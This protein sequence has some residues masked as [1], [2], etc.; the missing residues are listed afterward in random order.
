MS[1]SD[2]THFQ[3]YTDQNRIKHEILTKYLGAYVVALKG[4]AKLIHYVDGFAGSGAY[5]ETHPGSPILA[6]ELLAKSGLKFA[7]SFVENTPIHYESL[8]SAVAKYSS[9]PNLVEEIY[10]KNGAFAEHIAAVMSR[11][12]YKQYS[13]VA[14]FAFVDP[15]GAEDVHLQDLGKVLERSFGECLLLWNY[16]AINRWLGLVRSHKTG[17]QKLVNVFGDDDAVDE[18]LKLYDE[19]PEGALREGLMLEVYVAQLRMYASHIVPFC[20]KAKK[21]DRTSHYLIHCCNHGLPFKIMKEVMANAAT[22][23]GEPGVYEFLSAVKSKLIWTPVLDQARAAVI[24][25]LAGG[26]CS[27]LQ[28]YNEWVQRPDCLLTEGDFRSLLIDLESAGEIVVV[29]S[30][31][32]TL[33]PAEKRVSRKGRSTLSGR[34]FVRLP[35]R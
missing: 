3:Q 11:S 34:Y 18:A 30:N 20:I 14:T 8:C 26:P 29:A 16:D 27:V 24:S 12:I 15:C 23:G 2:K 4:T 10:C 9:T 7:V 33:A 28:F 22:P 5:A 13:P 1:K 6:V 25:H 32:L 17:T 21:S 19:E 35:N 31:G